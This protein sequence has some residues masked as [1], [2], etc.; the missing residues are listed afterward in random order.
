MIDTE[1]F[2]QQAPKHSNPGIDPT[3]N[4]L[5]KLLVP[6]LF[7]LCLALVVKFA[8]EFVD[9]EKNLAERLVAI[10]AFRLIRQQ[11]FTLRPAETN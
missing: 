10:R 11:K 1:N 7:L 6:L 2:R 9:P 3:A 5:R 4:D 8:E